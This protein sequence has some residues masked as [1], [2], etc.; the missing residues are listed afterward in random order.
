MCS[1]V[2]PQEDPCRSVKVG[3]VL[4]E[5]EQASCDC[6]SV[7]TWKDSSISCKDRAGQQALRYSSCACSWSSND[8]RTCTLPSAYRTTY[9]NQIQVLVVGS[10]QY[11]V[12]SQ[13]T[14]TNTRVHGQLENAL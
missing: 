11:A 1:P 13:C 7:H 9:A 2:S 14:M 4:L 10:A 8:C 5:V 6:V 12:L 3:N